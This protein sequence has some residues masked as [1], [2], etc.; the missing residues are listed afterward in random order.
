VEGVIDGPHNE[1]LFAGGRGHDEDRSPQV[2]VDLAFVIWILTF[3]IFLIA[4]P[5]TGRHPGAS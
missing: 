3:D 5:L 2:A 1:F 4:T